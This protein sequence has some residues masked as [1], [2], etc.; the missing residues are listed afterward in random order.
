MEGK[1]LLEVN[2]GHIVSP[3]PQKKIKDGKVDKVLAV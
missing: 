2:L 1:S 3:S